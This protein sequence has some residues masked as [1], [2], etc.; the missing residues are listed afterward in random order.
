MRNN[1]CIP[2]L[3]DS[4]GPSSSAYKSRTVRPRLEGSGFWLW[5]GATDVPT[6][7]QQQIKENNDVT[8]V[9]YSLVSRVFF[10][11][12]YFNYYDVQ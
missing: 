4:N 11:Y 8:V 1:L 2:F 5:S 7:E 9:S 12:L 3:Q 6:Q 10:C